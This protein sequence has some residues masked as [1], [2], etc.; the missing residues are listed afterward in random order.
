MYVKLYRFRFKWCQRSTGYGLVVFLIK[1]Y[2]LLWFTVLF[3]EKEMVSSLFTACYSSWNYASNC[4]VW[5]KVRFINVLMKIKATYSYVGWW[6]THYL[7]WVPQYGCPCLHVFL[8]F[9]VKFWTKCSAIP[10]VEKV[11]VEWNPI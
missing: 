4:L 11:E 10:L 2:W 6:R 9:H 3:N 7:C 5:S 1:V 8:L